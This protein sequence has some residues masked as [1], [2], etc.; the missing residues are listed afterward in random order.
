MPSS[1]Q[2]CLI[3]AVKKS[4]TAEA[5]PFVSFIGDEKAFLLPL[6]IKEANQWEE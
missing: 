4:G 6:Q 2:P 5:S 3:K 1:E